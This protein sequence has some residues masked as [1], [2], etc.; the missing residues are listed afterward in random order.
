MQNGGRSHSALSSWPKGSATPSGQGMKGSFAEVGSSL[1]VDLGSAVHGLFLKRANLSNRQGAKIA[2]ANKI[3]VFNCGEPTP[4][5]LGVFGV[6]AVKTG[7]HVE[8]QEKTM[9]C[10]QF[11]KRNRRACGS[12]WRG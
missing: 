1:A 6:L 3:A 10:Q 9:I 12:A 2:K 4:G 11:R 7:A 5:E 8:F